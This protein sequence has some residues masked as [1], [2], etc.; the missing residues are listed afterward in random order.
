MEPSPFVYIRYITVNDLLIN[1]E[2][3]AGTITV[4]D[5]GMTFEG[6]GVQFADLEIAKESYFGKF[7]V[8]TVKI[9]SAIVDL[10][11][12]SELINFYD[13]ADD[14]QK[15]G[16]A[17]DDSKLDASN[18]TENLILIGGNGSTIAGDFVG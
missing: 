4:T 5:D 11:T 9:D 14:L 10:G 1:S 15:I 18:E 17:S 6:Y 7:A 3:G 2:N 16:F 13:A 12:S 8:M